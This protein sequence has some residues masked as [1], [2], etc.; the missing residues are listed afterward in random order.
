MNI[1]GLKIT[2]EYGYKYH[3]FFLK[4]PNNS[5]SEYI[6]SELFEYILIPNYSLTSAIVAIV[7]IVSIRA[8]RAIKAIC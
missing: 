5:V 3:S 2:S 7:S 6:R 4:T 8:I 1:F